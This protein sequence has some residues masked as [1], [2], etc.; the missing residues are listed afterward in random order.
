[1]LTFYTLTRNHQKEKLRQQLH[2]H[3]HHK[4]KILA[5]KSKEVKD[6]LLEKYKTLMNMTQMERYTML[7]DQKN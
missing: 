3:Q 7:M 6:L 4:N 1:M 2:L 5:N